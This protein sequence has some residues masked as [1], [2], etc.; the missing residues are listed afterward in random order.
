MTCCWK[1]KIESKHSLLNAAWHISNFI[2]LISWIT[3]LLSYLNDIFCEYYAFGVRHTCPLLFS[4]EEIIVILSGIHLLQRQ[5]KPCKLLET[6]LC[7][8]CTQCLPTI[9]ATF[10]IVDTA[11]SVKRQCHRINLLPVG[12]HIS[13]SKMFKVMFHNVKAWSHYFSIQ[14]MALM[15]VININQSD[16]T[17][18][19]CFYW[20]FAL[21]WSR[22][23][24]DLKQETHAWICLSSRFQ[25][26]ILGEMEQIFIGLKCNVIIPFPS[27]QSNSR[28]FVCIHIYLH[29]HTHTHRFITHTQIYIYNDMCVCVDFLFNSLSLSIVQNVVVQIAISFRCH[30]PHFHSNM[31]N[32]Q[33]Y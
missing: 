1:R 13:T 14:W 3:L 2:I 19:Q 24:T 12:L 21:R 32:F 22:L 31:T 16:N 18:H 10:T 7:C 25:Q 33:V 4:V 6:V 26:N 23:E 20:L 8:I 17:L 11:T 27:H 5:G 29:T 30:P 15:Q 28:V 9:F